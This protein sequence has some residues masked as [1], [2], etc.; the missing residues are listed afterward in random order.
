MLQP[1]VSP[2]QA[3]GGQADPKASGQTL[4]DG[5]SQVKPLRKPW[6]LGASGQ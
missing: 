2:R 5:E 6:P 3:V 4:Q 1:T